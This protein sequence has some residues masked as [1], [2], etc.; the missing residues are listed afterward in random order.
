[1]SERFEHRPQVFVGVVGPH[2]IYVG[3]ADRAQFDKIAAPCSDHGEND[4][5][6]VL[7]KSVQG[8]GVMVVFQYWLKSKTNEAFIADHRKRR[9]ERERNELINS[10]GAGPFADG[11]IRDRIAEIDAELQELAGS[12][13]SARAP[14]SFPPG[15]AVSNPSPAPPKPAETRR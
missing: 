10:F 14:G 11:N 4:D 1:M 7:V 3:I 6:H 8:Y 5:G 2:V 9:L 12:S 15:D 13:S